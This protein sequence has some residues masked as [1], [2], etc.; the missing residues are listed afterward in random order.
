MGILEI[1]IDDLGSDAVVEDVVIGAFGCMVVSRCAGLS[2]SFRGNCASA[3]CDTGHGHGISR[4]GDLVGMSAL[5]LAE[6]AK[7]DNLLE[8]SVGIAALNSLIDSPRTALVEMNAYELIAER[9]RGKRVAVVGH[10]PFVE[11]LRGMADVRLIQKEPW[12]REEALREADEKIPGCDI[13]A[14]TGSSLINHTFDHILSLSRGAFVIVLGQ[15]TPMSPK[16]FQMGVAA[17]CGTLVDDVATARRFIMQGATFREM[18]GIRR[19]AM[20]AHSV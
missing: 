20:F 2:S 3:R 5:K 10:F 1:L 16:L 7:S 11:R 12:E 17:L 9:S 19:V 6:Y 14:I 18:R 8:A 15:S 4:T 13:V